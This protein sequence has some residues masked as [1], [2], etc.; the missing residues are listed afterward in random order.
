[1]ELANPEYLWLFVLLIPFTALYI[2]KMRKANA[3]LSMSS[4]KAFGKTR[5]PLKA[6]LRHGL[7]IL[8]LGSIGA[9]IIV[10]CRPQTHDNWRSTE[11]EGTDIVIA[12]DISTSMLTKDFVPNRLESAKKMAKQFVAGRP[13]DNIGVVIFAGESYTGLPM[14]MDHATVSNY[15]DN[16][17]VEMLE[18]GTAIGDG[19]ATSINRLKDGKAK[20]RSIILLT[21]GTNNT[22]IM[23]PG[24]AAQQ[25]KQN[26]IKIYTIGVGKDGYADVLNYDQFGRPYYQKVKATID[27]ATLSSIAKTTQG[28]FFR[29]TDEKSLQKVFD[30]ID[31]LET[32]VM[33]V[34]NFSHTED[35]PGIWPWLALGLFFLELLLRHTYF[36]TLP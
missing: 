36:R 7:F 2:L 9:L 17:N 16:L 25:A 21:D 19:I 33:E 10:L 22:G 29:A 23:T 34:Q 28:K 13:N 4:L 26:K 24:D 1:M 30:E 11:T 35:A 14:T 5:M 8:R 6:A 20:S 15:I 12:M 3:S 27:G 32:T 31:G 18:D